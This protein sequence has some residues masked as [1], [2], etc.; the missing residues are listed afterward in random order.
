MFGMY[1][2]S[3]MNDSYFTEWAQASR[4]RVEI[5][6]PDPEGPSQN[7]AIALACT[8]CIYR[9]VGT[10]L[11][12]QQSPLQRSP[13]GWSKGSRRV[14]KDCSGDIYYSGFISRSARVPGGAE[15][16]GL[17]SPGLDVPCLI[18]GGS[19][20]GGFPRRRESR[21]QEFARHM[22]KKA[23]AGRIVSGV[24]QVSPIKAAQ[25]QSLELQPHEPEHR[26]AL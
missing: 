18:D 19:I 22:G 15:Q 17:A 13:A 20:A 24:L 25:D 8:V 5:E 7:I 21:E 1:F 12:S 6:P 11:T 23:V 16:S 26:R 14:D 10:Y 9:L 4:R 3:S 2:L